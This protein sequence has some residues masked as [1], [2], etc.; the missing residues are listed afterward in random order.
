M[1]PEKGIRKKFT[2]IL[3]VN[4]WYGKIFEGSVAKF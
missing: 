2:K 3:C 1:Q 4:C